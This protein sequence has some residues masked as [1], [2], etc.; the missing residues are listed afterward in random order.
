MLS[1]DSDIDTLSSTSADWGSYFRLMQNITLEGNHTPIGNGTIRFTGNFDG[2]G[3]VIKNL[4]IYHTTDHAGLFGYANDADIYDL[5]V[6][7]SLDGV[8]STGDLVGGLVG[9]IAYSNVRNCYATGNVT[10]RY[11]VGGLV[12]Y[13]ESS[14]VSNSYIIGNVT[15]DSGVG[16]LVGSNY[17]GAVSSSYAT[18]NVIG[19]SSVGGLVGSNGVGTVSNCFATGNATGTYYVGGLVGRIENGAVSSSYA[20]GNAIGDSYVGGLL[21]SNGDTVSV[22]NCFATGNVI[23]D[24]YVGGLVG[25]NISAVSNCYYSGTPASGAGIATSYGNF[26]SFTFVSG[27]TGLAWNAGGNIITTADN[28]VFVWKIDDGFSLPYFQNQNI[29]GT[30]PVNSSVSGAWVYVNGTNQTVQ[31]NTILSLRP[32]YYNITIMKQYYETPATQTVNVTEGENTG[33]EFT[34][35]PSLPVTGFM[36]N[37]SSGMAPL[38]VNFTDQSVGIVDSWFWNFD[39]GN[40]STDQNPTHIYMDVG[41]YDVSLTATNIA[42]SNISTQLSYITVAIAP[43]ANFTASATSGTAPFA[44]T[45]TDNSTNTPT[46]WA[47]NFGD[48]A[49]SSVQNPSH[50]YTSAGTY[51]VSLNALNAGGYNISTQTVYIT[52][53]PGSSGSSGSSTRVSVSPGQ[54]PESVTSTYTAVKHV[55]GGSSVE[56]DLS[57]TGSPVIGISFYAKD[58]EGLVVAKV[59]VLSDKPEGI[60]NPPGNSYQLMSI[61]VGSQGTISIHNADNILILFKVN[62]QWIEENNIDV[63]TIRMT[64]FHEGQWN[65]LPTYKEREEDDY[66]Y[67]Y[68]ET[69]GFSIFEVVG[70]GIY[71][72]PEDAPFHVKSPVSFKEETPVED[73]DGF[74]FAYLILGIMVVIGVGYV[75]M[76]KQ[77]SGGEQ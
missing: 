51:T 37:V 30:L 8:V 58:N 42:G 67:F 22:S 48:G 41:T 47:W 21:G 19:A 24:S 31:T 63:S 46:L 13:I 11:D 68:S 75:V 40:T 65:N 36:S 10:G 74:G 26:T 4:T 17:G 16:G 27:D 76:K 70:D 34:L 54:P 39:D 6:E 55:L 73:K 44:V 62:R 28:S 9:Y 32:G 33:I 12:G 2:S 14:T 59:Q 49:T 50:T 38:S 7:T 35:V 72:P 3:F 56:Y 25:L 1:T 5:G 57:G 69:P 52:V 20:T 64:R 45:F 53:A 43:V 77:K 15:G 60:P 71:I 61:D 66:I 18:V 29:P 23:G